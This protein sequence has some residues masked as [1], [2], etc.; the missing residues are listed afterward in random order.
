MNKGTCIEIADTNDSSDKET[1]LKKRKL[2]SELA[3]E[4]K[5]SFWNIPDQSRLVAPIIFEELF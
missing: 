4:V 3:F 5:E 1:I 2:S